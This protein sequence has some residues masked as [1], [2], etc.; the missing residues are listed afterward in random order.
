V[1][2]FPDDCYL[3]QQGELLKERELDEDVMLEEIPVVGQLRTPIE[4]MMAEDGQ[5]S[6]GPTIDG[7]QTYMQE[8][9][10][11]AVLA[12]NSSLQAYIERVCSIVRL[13]LH[14]G[15]RLV[16]LPRQIVYVDQD[17]E[18]RQHELQKAQHSQGG[19]VMYIGA[20]AFDP[21][22]AVGWREVLSWYPM[23]RVRCW[24][25]SMAIAQQRL[26]GTRGARGQIIFGIQVGF[27]ITS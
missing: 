8:A 2:E 12:V 1:I 24:A 22:H 19:V 17:S 23:E 5:S 9:S 10:R 13:P 4:P 15:R 6:L 21:S 14:V 25:I 27:P 26:W 7:E 16:E 20:L 11:V 3:Q 18:T